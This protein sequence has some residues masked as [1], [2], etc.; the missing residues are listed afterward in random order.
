MA[1]EKNSEEYSQEESK[2]RFEAALRGAR[3]VGLEP[4]KDIS[5]KRLKLEMEAKAK[6]RPPKKRATQRQRRLPD[7]AG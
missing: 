5:P 4:M 6:A 3:E 2:R 1:K 7:N